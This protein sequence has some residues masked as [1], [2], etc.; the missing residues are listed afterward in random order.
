MHQSDNDWSMDTTTTT[1]QAKLWDL[2]CLLHRYIYK[3][4][5]IVLCVWHQCPASSAIRSASIDARAI[6]L[7]FSFPFNFNEWDHELL[8][9]SWIDLGAALRPD[10]LWFPLL[11]QNSNY[12][13]GH[14]NHSHAS[15]RTMSLN[16]LLNRLSLSFARES[17]YVFVWC[18][19][20]H[21]GK[22]GHN[23][24]LEFRTPCIGDFCHNDSEQR[25]RSNRIHTKTKPKK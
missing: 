23:K 6:L 18:S 2:C 10:G 4:I 15:P 11:P 17:V 8:S 16:S 20:C 3:N 22:M 1:I 12:F 19:A 9:P 13:H 21:C 24:L 5:N 14:S 7:P 25:A